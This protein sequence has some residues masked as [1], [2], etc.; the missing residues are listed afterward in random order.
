MSLAGAGGDN[1][2]PVA[3]WEP[4]KSCTDALSQ[5]RMVYNPA[6]LGGQMAVCSMPGDTIPPFP[7]SMSHE[8]GATP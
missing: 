6:T 2:P 8:E 1:E 4:A 3:G 7:N 5:E